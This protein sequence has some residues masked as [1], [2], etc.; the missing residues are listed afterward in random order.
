[1]STKT[2]PAIAQAAPALFVLL[3]STGFIGAR[4]GAPYSEPMTFLAIRMGLVLALLVPISLLL[5]AKWPNP[6]QSFHAFV[7]GLLIHGMYLA[8]IFWSIDNGMPAGLAALIMGL[9]PVMTAFFARLILKEK[10]TRNHI[11]GFVL[12]LVG[13]GL[14]LYPRL[15]GGAFSVTPL[16]VTLVG[17]AMLCISFGT[18]YQKRFAANVDMRTATIWQYCAAGLFCAGLSFAAESQTIVWSGEFV[19][20]LA[21]LTLVLSIGAIFLLLWL[22]EHG[23][24]SNIAALFYM[25]PAVTAVISYFLFDEPITLM[26]VLGIVVTATGVVIASRKTHLT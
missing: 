11:Y 19:F 18:V 10:V 5:G 16:Q 13:I 21:W 26:Q 9:Q 7:T 8:G 15:S 2:A 3:W 4:M 6:K 14:V 25:I 23:A 20:A 22:I 1:M 17:L 12:G 24:V